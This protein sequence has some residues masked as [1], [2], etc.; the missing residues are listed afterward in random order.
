MLAHA[1][2][3]YIRCE[4]FLS[5]LVGI[6]YYYA[7]A[8]RG[9]SLPPLGCVTVDFDDSFFI[10]P[11]AERERDLREVAAGLLSPWEYRMKHYGES[12]EIARAM[13]FAMN[14]AKEHE[15]KGEIAD[16]R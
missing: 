4:R 14:G 10:D 15:L 12:A 16:G 6:G 13:I 9:I 1:S 3:H 8:L 2:K 5:E 7:T 11:T